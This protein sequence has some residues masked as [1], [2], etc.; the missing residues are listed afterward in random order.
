[1]SGSSA[2]VRS[3]RFDFGGPN[4]QPPGMGIS[5]RSITQSRRPSRSSARQ[6]TA[7]QLAAAHASRGG[8]SPEREQS[9]VA[10]VCQ[11]RAQLPAGPRRCLALGPRWRCS[12]RGRA[13]RD[14]SPP[15]GVPKP[16]AEDGMSQ[17]PGAG[18]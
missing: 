8:E 2:I 12:V 14:L 17:T 4:V 9:I 5:C 1:M 13:A 3:E 11:E 10:D 18:G 16:A 6:V 15:L 7:E